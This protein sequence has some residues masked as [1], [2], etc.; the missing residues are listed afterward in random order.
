MVAPVCQSAP[1]KINLT[2]RI[3]GRREDGYH[4]LVSLVAFAPD[5][6]DTVTVTPGPSNRV[7]FSGPFSVGLDAGPTTVSLALRLLAQSLVA[8]ASAPPGPQPAPGLQL[9][10]VVVEKRI[11][12]ASGLGGGSADAAAVLRAVR[13]LNTERQTEVDWLTIAR[14][15]GAD[16][17]VCL[18]SRAQIMSGVGDELAPVASL[19]KLYTVLIKTDEPALPDKTQRVFE[20]LNAGP[21]EMV[22][23]PQSTKNKVT[24]D[25]AEAVAAF[26]H[27]TGNTLLEPARA[28]MPSL[29]APLAMLNAQP[30]CLAA[31]LSGAGPTVFGLFADR[32]G[33]ESAA[34][35]IQNDAPSWWVKASELV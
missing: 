5:I 31:S 20:A 16:V 11:P 29:D 17:P 30:S 7:T 12:L 27:G 32:D 9:G 21:I 13:H 3:L 8:P 15:I 19:P 22:A 35:T 28:L 10:A 4:Q 23:Q 18:T 24:F 2:L 26:V 1:A 14:Q 33:A 25:C 6:S 34:R